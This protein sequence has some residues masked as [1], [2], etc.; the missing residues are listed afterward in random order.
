MAP[1]LVILTGASG[2]G[3]TTLARAIQQACPSHCKVLLF[4]SVGGPSVE[5]M[6]AFGD[7][8]QPGGAW[9]RATTLQWM[10]RIAVKRRAGISVLFEGQMR[11]AFIHEALAV[12]GIEGAHIIL[13]DC[14]DAT[15]RARLHDD[16]NQPEL[17]NADMMAWSR[18]LREEATQA[19]CEILDTGTIPL[20]NCRHRILKLLVNGRH[21]PCGTCSSS[22][23]HVF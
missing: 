12:S 21:Y 13:V 7:G 22:R 8:H 23:R 4:D 1:S 20:E 17:A 11:I 2:S 9:Q 5:T 3:K 18:Y 16:R 15:R 14:E 19:G 10:E 6:R